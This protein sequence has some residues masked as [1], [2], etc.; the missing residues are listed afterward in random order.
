MLAR[1]Y[2]SVPLVKKIVKLLVSLAYL[3]PAKVP[4]GF[5]VRL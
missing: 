4:R 2:E 1:E 5:E 3:E